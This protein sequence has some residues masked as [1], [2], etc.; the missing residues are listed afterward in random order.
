MGIKSDGSR[1]PVGFFKD[2]DD[3]LEL[4]SADGGSLAGF[5]LLKSLADAQN[6]LERRVERCASLGRDQLGCLVE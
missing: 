4:G 5:P 2:I 1:P 3:S 6:D